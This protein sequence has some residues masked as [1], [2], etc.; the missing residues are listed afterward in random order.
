MDPVRT[1]H[2]ERTIK[3][4]GGSDANDLPAYTMPT[5]HGNTICSVWKPTLEERERIANGENIRLIVW[6]QQTP[7]V[8][9]DVTAEK[10]M[11]TSA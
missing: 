7:P 11:R 9:M 1:E 4:P 6:A 10:V 3:L 5:E 2:T 8:A